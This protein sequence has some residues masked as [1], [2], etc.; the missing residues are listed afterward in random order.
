MQDGKKRTKEELEKILTAKQKRFC[1]YYVIDWNGAA[2]AKDA[3]Y[4]ED[5]ARQLASD[6]LSKDYIQ[7][8]INLIKD[9][10]AEQL[11]LSKMMVV[12]EWMRIAFGDVT[13]MFEVTPDGIVLSGDLDQGSIP[14]EVSAT[15]AEV[16]NTKYGV[17]VKFHSKTTALSQIALLMGWNAPEKQ[18]VELNDK[19]DKVTKIEV[20]RSGRTES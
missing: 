4:S 9:D 10:I 7:E 3:G 12:R 18:Q 19:T 6:T 15:I 8:Y 13:D 20:V 11:G 16:E 2:A 17:R 5:A 14:K 1:E